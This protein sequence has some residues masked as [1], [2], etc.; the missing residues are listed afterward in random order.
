MNFDKK[1]YMFECEHRT[2]PTFETIQDELDKISNDLEVAKEMDIRDELK[3]QLVLE[4]SDKK[5]KLIQELHKAIDDKY[6]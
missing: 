4:L 3:F 5:C 6:L 2:T 1:I